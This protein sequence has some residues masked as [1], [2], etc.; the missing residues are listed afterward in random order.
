YRLA[1]LAGGG[2]ALTTLTRSALRGMACRD[3]EQIAERRQRREMERGRRGRQ[4]GSGAGD[5]N[6]ER[7]LPDRE[8]KR[9]GHHHCFAVDP[10]LHRAVR[11]DLEPRRLP[12]QPVGELA[13]LA[14]GLQ[15]DETPRLLGPADPGRD[16]AEDSVVQVLAGAEAAEMIELVLVVRHQN[17]VSGVITGP[18]GTGEAKIERLRARAEQRREHVGRGLQLRV[19]VLGNLN[20]LGVEPER[21]VVDEYPAIHLAYRDAPLHRLP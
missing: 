3:G 11:A 15:S 14:D 4:A 9:R 13:Y 10:D 8:D 21:R 20:D 6:P 1:P 7:A 16:N 5:S 2:A 19:P 18:I 12:L 17:H